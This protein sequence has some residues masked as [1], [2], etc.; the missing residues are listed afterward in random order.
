MPVLTSMTVI[1]SVRS[2]T[3]VP[4]EGSH[5]LR[6]SALSSC[7]SIRYSANTSFG[8]TWRCSRSAELRRDVSDVVLQR[9]PRVV[10]LDDEAGEVLV[11][12]VAHD[13]DEQVRLLV[14]ER[15]RLGLVG[16]RGLGLALDD[17]PL[18]LQ[19][20]DV[21]LQRLVA[22]A[23]RGG[24]DDHPGLAGDDLLEHVLEP[25]AL[26]VGQLAADPGGAAARH[27]DQESAGQADLGGE[28]GALVPDRVLRDLHEHAVAAGQGLLDAPR[29]AAETGGVPVD[30]ARV[31]HRVAAAA[32]VDERGLHAG[33]HV[34]HAAEVDVADHATCRSRRGPP[35]DEVLDEDVVLEHRDLD[36]VA[37]LP[38][39]HRAVDGL[40]AGQ[41]L[42]LGQ[43]RHP[44]AAGV[45]TVAAA[46]ALGLQPGGAADALHA[47]ARRPRAA[48][49]AGATFVTVTVPGGS[50]SSP[51]SAVSSPAAAAA[52]P[53]AAA[54]RSARV[55]VGRRRPRPTP[56]RPRCRRRSPHRS[57]AH[58]TR[59]PR[60]PR[61]RRCPRWSRRRHR[62][63]PRPRP[64]PRRPR[65]AAPAAVPSSSSSP[66]VGTC[67]VVGSSVAPSSAADVGGLL[68]DR[69]R[70]ARRR[71]G[72]AS[73]RLEQR[74][75]RCEQR[76]Q[77]GAGLGGLLAPCPR[78]VRSGPVLSG[79]VRSCESA[80]PSRRPARPAPDRA[81][82]LPARPP[83]RSTL[84][85]ALRTSTPEVGQRREHLAAGPCDAVWPARAPAS[86]PAGRPVRVR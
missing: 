47:V 65:R 69:A 42:G 41:E 83:S 86:S 13:L 68:V 84:D 18:R 63:S 80:R 45:A 44:A 54:A 82:R 64:R 8:P 50:V 79:S 29:L 40:A 11:E 51:T 6:S 27:V 34:L 77:R 60:R 73:G 66:V 67:G 39:D 70:P 24:A 78:T 20:A 15:R 71:R 56:R 61:P 38:D 1:A 21:A 46:L 30:L 58:R 5:T 3:S 76:R 10:A 25:L 48:R 59:C 75:G 55:L 19:A 16:A 2:I 32:D 33:Q 17:L 37:A 36:A 12:L 52:A 22:H 72:R 7:S 85:W 35:G 28:P 57:P 81:R 62:R 74:R 4:P 49:A 14:E 26:D 9:V 31:E 23:L 53:A 43:D